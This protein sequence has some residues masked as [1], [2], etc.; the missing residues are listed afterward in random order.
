MI[1]TITGPT[2]RSRALKLLDSRTDAKSSSADEPQP[3]TP[4][5]GK[6][7]RQMVGTEKGTGF[8]TPN[9]NAEHKRR[10]PRKRG[11]NVVSGELPGGVAPSP[12]PATTT[13]R[14]TPAGDLEGDPENDSH[15]RAMGDEYVPLRPPP[16]PRV[17]R[18]LRGPKKR[19]KEFQVQDAQDAG[20]KSLSRK[21]SCG[22][23]MDGDRVLGEPP[24][25]TGI[26]KSRKGSKKNPNIK[27]SPQLGKAVL[28]KADVKGRSRP[29]RQ[30]GE[31]AS[32]DDYVP[33]RPPPMPKVPKILKGPKPRPNKASSMPS[34]LEKG[35]APSDSDVEEQLANSS[36]AEDE[37]PD[38]DYVPGRPPPLPRVPK[39][40]KGPKR[41]P[42]QANTDTPAV[43]DIASVP[44]NT[45]EVSPLQSSSDDQKTDGDYVPGKPPPMPKVPKLLRGLK[46]KPRKERL[47]PLVTKAKPSV[48]TDPALIDTPYPLLT[49]APTTPPAPPLPASKKPQQ[50]AKSFPIPRI[51]PIWLSTPT[52]TGSTSHTHQPPL[53]FQNGTIYCEPCFHSDVLRWLRIRDGVLKVLRLLDRGG[54]NGNEPEPAM[55]ALR[56]VAGEMV[57]AEGYGLEGPDGGGDYVEGTEGQSGKIEDGVEIEERSGRCMWWKGKMGPAMRLA[58][59]PPDVIGLV[60]LR[61][62]A[63]RAL[64]SLQPQ[65]AIEVEVTLE[66]LRQDVGVGT[67][68]LKVM[69]VAYRSMLAGIKSADKG[70]DEPPVADW[71]RRDA[72]KQPRTR[73]VKNNR[74]GSEGSSTRQLGRA[75]GAMT[76]TIDFLKSIGEKLAQA[77]YELQTT[78]P[79]KKRRSPD[80]FRPTASK[81]RKS[82]HR[83]DQQQGIPDPG[84]Q[85]IGFRLVEPRPIV[86]PCVYC[87]ESGASHRYNARYAS[88]CGGAPLPRVQPSILPAHTTQ[89]MN[90]Q[91][92]PIQPW[93]N[94]LQWVFVPSLAKP[95]PGA[96]EHEIHTTEAWFQLL[97]S[98]REVRVIEIFSQAERR[99]RSSKKK[100]RLGIDE[101]DENGNTLLLRFI[102]DM[103]GGVT[104]VVLMQTA[105]VFDALFL[106]NKPKM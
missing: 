47:A 51:H 29:T 39:I 11:H 41:Q 75:L 48:F 40:L 105:S 25:P 88:P 74:N 96:M 99:S 65:D 71:V 94:A 4:G 22:K 84:L 91:D 26:S 82:T 17:P 102:V 63:E 92:C 60:M 62:L 13:S 8:T 7:S 72:A 14:S 50:K 100:A 98:T 44:K 19:I 104:R 86:L 64:A 58:E 103:T 10:T 52:A 54:A 2:T 89:A 80:G 93:T 21:K 43:R 53:P 97:T 24:P 23:Q 66:A 67:R 16:M 68:F 32:D 78:V 45:K 101:N 20:R 46:K 69:D 106:G 76:L 49:G 12:L 70:F 30:P 27:P 1:P 18:I 73:T 15:N 83:P 38:E 81:R 5:R 59:Y 77:R 36:N 85:D 35:H 28:T 42:K 56:S 9:A 90:A 33:G 79:G 31:E 95:E 3:A 55:D 37:E 57:E 61:I 87:A 34:V 6:A